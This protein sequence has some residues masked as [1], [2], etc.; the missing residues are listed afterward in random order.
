MDCFTVAGFTCSIYQSLSFCNRSVYIVYTVL[1]DVAVYVVGKDE[2]DELAC[3][4]M[5]ILPFSLDSFPTSQAGFFLLRKSF[6]LP[7]PCVIFLCINFIFT[8]SSGRSDL[9]SNIIDKGCLWQSS[10]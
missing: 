5:T 8:S 9:C 10:N 4:K 2:Y 7:D 3:K 6:V 1:G